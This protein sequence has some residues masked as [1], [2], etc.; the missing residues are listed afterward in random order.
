[1]GN[2]FHHHQVLIHLVQFKIF[3]STYNLFLRRKENTTGIV[4]SVISILLCIAGVIF[5]GVMYNT[6][7]A[8][9]FCLDQDT[10][11]SYGDSKYYPDAAQCA[12]D[13]SQTCLCV[14]GSDHLFTHNIC[15]LFNLLGAGNCGQILT[16]LPALLLTSLIFT[17]LNLMLVLYYLF[18]CVL[19]APAAH[20]HPLVPTAP[21]AAAELAAP[22]ISAVEAVATPVY[23]PAATKHVTHVKLS[24]KVSMI[25]DEA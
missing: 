14:Q 3:S 7:Q 5:D 11:E 19:T 15:Y 16:K 22:T 1:M 9:D 24:G 4:L 18:A 20:Q 13:D 17:L 8:L 2:G 21:P 6:A 12:S 10:G 25:I 23:P